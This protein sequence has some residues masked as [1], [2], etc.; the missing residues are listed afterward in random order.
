MLLLCACW[1]LV[2]I[3]SSKCTL[4][5][6]S[7]S[8]MQQLVHFAVYNP[9]SVK[10]SY[11]REDISCHLKG[12]DIIAVPGTA[13]RHSAIV[14]TPYI[15]GRF[16]HHIRWSWGFGLAAAYSNKSAG[17]DIF[18]R[19]R[20]FNKRNITRVWSPPKSMQGRAGAVRI[21]NGGTDICFI[22]GYIPPFKGP[23]RKKA[24]FLQ[25]LHIFFS[26]TYDIVAAMPNRCLPIIAMDGNLKYGT[27]EGELLRD[28][29]CGRFITGECCL[30][31][32]AL[33]S[34]LHKS[35]MALLNTYFKCGPTFF[36]TRGSRSKP[37][38]FCMPR[39]AIPLVR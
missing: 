2:G 28:S 16:P 6:P 38:M 33:H 11:R 35:R 18:I 15:V 12:I 24:A 36:G 20:S 34:F 21:Q 39:A 25:L 14:P 7:S 4:S 22:A 3:P 9:L 29:T 19:K 23:A 17:I 1:R 8:I 27:L 32:K 30:A 31:G 26:W 13:Q 37:D 10:Q 5:V